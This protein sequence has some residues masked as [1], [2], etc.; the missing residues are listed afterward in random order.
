MPVSSRSDRDFDDL[1]RQACSEDTS[2][3]DRSQALWDVIYHPRVQSAFD[4]SPGKRKLDQFLRE[5]KH[6]NTR[7]GRAAVILAY[8][9]RASIEW[10]FHKY[11]NY[12]PTRGRHTGQKRIRRYYTD[13]DSQESFEVFIRRMLWKF[14]R[15][16]QKKADNEEIAGDV[17]PDDQRDDSTVVDHSELAVSTVSDE[18]GE[19][20]GA[21]LEDFSSGP[22]DP[23]KVEETWRCFEALKKSVWVGQAAAL[24]SGENAAALEKGAFLNVVRH[25]KGP[26]RDVLIHR[27]INQKTYKEIGQ[28]MAEDECWPNVDLSQGERSLHDAARNRIRNSKGNCKEQFEG[29]PGA[30]EVDIE[31]FL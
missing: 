24:E 12:E 5:A 25:M 17:D 7:R 3:E 29:L 31:R 2:E 16:L 6:Q 14:A 27:V 4:G 22:M 9:S 15:Y 26:C 19:E 21:L 23:S 11:L 20:C 8:D 10:E 28:I 18:T 1:V 30:E 13:E